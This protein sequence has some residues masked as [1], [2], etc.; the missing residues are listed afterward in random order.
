MRQGRSH[1]NLTISL[2]I[3]YADCGGVN[4]SQIIDD[5]LNYDLTV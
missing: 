4:F 3:F 5:V 2:K 1:F